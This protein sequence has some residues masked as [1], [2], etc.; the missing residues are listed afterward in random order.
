M[1]N[2]PVKYQSKESKESQ[3]LILKSGQQS[4]FLNSSLPPSLEFG[5]WGAQYSAIVGHSGKF[6]PNPQTWFPNNQKAILIDTSPGQL[7]NVAAQVPHL[8][9]VISTGAELF[10]LMEIKHVNK[11]W[12]PGDSKGKNEIENS[13]ILEFLQQPNPL[14]ILQQY[15]YE[16]YVINAV[17]NKTFQHKISGL[18]FTDF[19]SMPS[20]MWLLPS[21]WMKINLFQGTNIFRQSDI[22]SIIESYEMLG[23]TYPY[24]VN[25][26]IYMAE[27]VGNNILNPIS[28]IESLQIPLSNIVAAMKSYNILTCERGP[29]GILVSTNKDTDGGLPFDEKEG[30]RIRQELKS[31]YSLDNQAGHIVFS[32]SN[33]TWVPMGYNVKEL[34]LFEGEES[35]FSKI[36]D[37]YRHDRAIYSQEKGSSLTTGNEKNEGIKNTIQNGLVPT[38]NKLMAQWTKHFIDPKSGERLVASYSHV[39]A[40]RE[41]ELQA[42]QAKLYTVQAMSQLLKDN[43]IDHDNYAEGAGVDMTGT[44]LPPAATPTNIIPPTDQQAS[45]SAKVNEMRR[46]RHIEYL[47]NSFLHQAQ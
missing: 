29:N 30:A 21:G 47:Y 44:A 25:K 14:Q 45:E 36:I 9:T 22:E 31:K 1:S 24:D 18:S 26:I 35:A 16:F 10:S 40:M 23:D 43:V 12:E 32:H 11:N 34:M 17:Y 39:P 28:R 3:E 8:N 4:Y 27:G 38:A 7:M 6:K 15:L 46:L 2:L 19:S 33:L 42:A 37:A 20:A 41:D 5:G 13:P